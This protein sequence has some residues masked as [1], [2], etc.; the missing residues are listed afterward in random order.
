[1]WELAFMFILGLFLNLAN[2]QL[3]KIIIWTPLS[4]Q[5]KNRVTHKA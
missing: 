1:M 2:D 5:Y 4:K 3:H